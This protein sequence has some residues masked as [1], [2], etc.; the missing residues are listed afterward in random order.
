[1]TKNFAGASEPFCSIEPRNSKDS[2]LMQVNDIVLGA[3]GFQKNCYEL[4][5]DTRR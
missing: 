2:E 3:I 5:P 1:M 4:N